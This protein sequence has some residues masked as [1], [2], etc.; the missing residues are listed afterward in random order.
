[1][2]ILAPTP[3]EALAL[4]WS[5]IPCGPDKRALVPWKRYQ[6]TRPTLDEI[7]RWEKTLR[8]AAWAIVTGAIS[9]RITLDF[10]G[11]AGVG[12]MRRLGLHPQRRTPSGGY[13]VDF[14]HPGSPV[15]TLNSKSKRE[16]GAK[17]PGLDIRGDGGY[18][19]FRGTTE[20][21]S[22]EWLDNFTDVPTGKLPGVL[23]AGNRRVDS[24]RLI[25]DAL[26]MASQG[27]NNSGAWLAAQLRDNGCSEGE[28]IGIDYASRCPTTNPSGDVE[29]YTDR[30]W[31]AT[32]RSIY[33]RPP[34][35]PWAPPGAMRMQGS[36]A[37]G[38]NGQSAQTQEPKKKAKSKVIEL[39]L[40]PSTAGSKTDL[41]WGFVLGDVG[42]GQRFLARHGNDVLCDDRRSKNPVWFYWDGM[43]WK[44][45][46][47]GVIRE[48]AH[49]VGIEYMHQATEYRCGDTDKEDAV[50]KRALDYLKSWGLSN[51]L[52]EARPY[53]L[54]KI[55]DFDQNDYL[56]NFRNGTLDLSTDPPLLRE[57]RREDRITTLIDFDYDPNALCPEF[58]GFLIATMGGNPDAEESEQDVPQQRTA[59]DMVNYLQR[60]FGCAITGDTS[61]KLIFVFNGETDTGKTTLLQ[62]IRGVIPEHSVVIPIEIL[63]TQ[64]RNSSIEE[65]LFALRGKRFAITSETNKNTTLNVA[66]IKQ[67][68]QG[69]GAVIAVTPKYKPTINFRETHK[70]FMDCNFRP[71]VW[72]GDEA[73]WNRLRII[74]FPHRIPREQQ[75]KDMK[76]QLLKERQGIMAWLVRGFL[77][78]RK[79]GLLT[80]ADIEQRSRAWRSESQ[81]LREFL[82]THCWVE[83]EWTG[84]DEDNIPIERPDRF[85]AVKSALWK[86][87]TKW[88]ATQ[89]GEHRLK[90][91]DF[92][93]EI[94]CLPGVKFGRPLVDGKQIG[95]YEGIALKP[96]S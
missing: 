25:R 94:E 56:L 8:P 91:T 33:S 15:P 31:S 19:I 71:R 40:A 1:M 17:Y 82:D 3:Q 2:A 80:P 45:T 61:E 29:P 58:E 24:E 14:A 27:R 83:V 84:K 57:H 77:A 50:R 28:A 41:L 46:S 12:T 18:V 23:H 74:N 39:V 16:L 73:I 13:H 6:T 36:P 86:R 7:N 49:Q 67:I 70:L 92:Y 60:V 88:F 21:G 66:R 76:E 87:Y 52:T 54:A 81:R 4:G 26:G 34:R 30:E 20:R 69:Q 62:T 32:V 85:V 35:E 5:V 68:T 64:D 55:E 11:E 42:N 95:A 9:G 43:R 47:E 44:G 72:G 53:V 65:A 51:A 78:C 59:V 10:D 22:Y 75:R 93:T 96:E 37:N 48:L 38:G 89:Q 79:D 90:K 63:M